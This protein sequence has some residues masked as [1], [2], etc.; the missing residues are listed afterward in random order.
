MNT[1]SARADILNNLLDVA[2]AAPAIERIRALQ[3]LA[4]ELSNED[5]LTK[6][7]Y[8]E[9]VKAFGLCNKGDFQALMNEAK[10]PAQKSKSN[11]SR[12][13][14]SDLAD[15]WIT[16]HP[17][18][19]YG[20]GEFRRYEGGI[21]LVVPLDTVKQEVVSIL[22]QQKTN[23]VRSTSNLV[24]S[25]VELSRIKVSHPDITW[26]SR[27]G[28][29]PCNN[30]VLD[31]SH[32]KLLNHSPDYYFTSKLSFNYDP[33]AK[34]PYF[35]RVIKSAIPEAESFLQEYAGYTLTPDTSFE[36]AVWLYGPSGCG[37]SSIL[38]GL[39]AMLGSR[40]GVL[41]L[42]EIER[43][44]FALT[45][46]EGKTL[47]IS[48]EQPSSFIQASYCLNAIISGEPILVDRKYREPVQLTSIAKL[49]WAMN[50]YPIV[51]DS[52]NGLF[53]RVKVIEFPPLDV[54]KR[55][56]KVKEAIKAEGAGV[57]NWALEGLDRLT[58]NG[59]FEIPDCVLAAT[60]DFKLR[61]DV[62][63]LFVEE[64]CVVG[65]GYKTRSGD[66]YNAYKNWCGKNGVKSKP[67]TTISDDWNRLGFSK[68][69]ANGHPFWRGVGIRGRS[70]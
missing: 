6:R 9:Q 48:T 46:L 16:L 45:N 17:L 41:G 55:D 47:M 25:V 19:I 49:A 65:D 33:S 57:L 68:Y 39:Q 30:G 28:L 69:E 27:E 51:K 50:E 10:D 22:E 53:R 62:P 31:I 12:P 24:N 5:H 44:R 70:V 15:I 23:G 18:T 59:C 4:K 29:L 35:L 14:D 3:A 1:D 67:I 32:R 63:K 52:T 43:S 2:K 36:I 20:L 8:F 11:L 58:T 37:K 34:C 21:W 42:G 60:E 7:F 54:D 61:N 38:V 66:L 13:S 26:D 64:M 40:S 56:R